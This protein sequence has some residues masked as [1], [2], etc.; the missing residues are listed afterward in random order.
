MSLDRID[1]PLVA[2]A[3]PVYNGE[4]FLAETMTCVQAQTY[5]NLVHVVVDNASTDA[6]PQIIARFMN[7][8]VPVLLSRNSETVPVAKNWN[9]AAAR[10]PAD[11]RYFQVLCADDLLLDPC[12][13]EKMVAVAE[14]DPAVELIGSAQYRGQQPPSGRPPA[15]ASRFRWGRRCQ[16]LFEQEVERRPACYGCLPPPRRRTSNGISSTSPIRAIDTD[17]CLRALSRGKFG[18]VHEPLHMFRIHD[19]QLS[20]VIH[21]N[22]PSVWDSLIEI[23]RW[24]PKV[25]P[26]DEAEACFRRHLRVVLRYMLAWRV[27]RRDVLYERHRDG[28]RDMGIRPGV[29]D[30]LQSVIEWPFIE[31]ADHWSQM[32]RR[33]H[34]QSSGRQADTA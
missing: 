28:L 27:Q 10:V 17:A 24:A 25:M 29:F 34:W 15:R 14:S 16:R 31:V 9:L 30:Y 2:I 5:S 19:G 7:R 3:T 18:F 1:R 33:R 21:T 8:R 32:S 22:R 26:P 20:N 12:A 6:T 11:A 4:A 13:V 23:K